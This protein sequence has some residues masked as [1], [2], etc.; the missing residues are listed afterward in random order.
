MTKLITGGTG[1]VGSELARMLVDRGEKVILF[2]IAPRYESI[3]S[4]KDKVTVIRGDLANWSEVLNAVSNNDV[5]SIFHLGAMLSIPSD[6]NPWGAYRVNANGMMHVL[7][8]ARLFNVEK[9]VF[10]STIAIY[11]SQADI[12]IEIDESTIQLAENMYGLT[13]LFSELLGKFYSKKFNLDFRVVRFPTVVGP[14]AKTKHM[15]Q[16]MAWMIDHALSGKPFEIWVEEGTRIPCFYYKDAANALLM[17]HDAPD[18]NIRTRAYN[19]AGISLTAKEFADIVRRHIPS[20]QITFKPDLEVM[21]M[22]GKGYGTIDESCAK[23]EWGWKIRFDMERM[24]KDFE[25]EYVA[26]NKS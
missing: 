23:N 15:A 26:S 25:K 4:I 21:K 2:D 22:V 9:V 16:Y 10:S 11:A 20:A 17:L 18:E 13:K 19:L 24:I 12:P 8:A 6:N 5:E 3:E 7:E 1:F 14:G